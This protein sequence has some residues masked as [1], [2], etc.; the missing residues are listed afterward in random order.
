MRGSTGLAILGMILAL[1]CGVEV[2]LHGPLT[3]ID[4]R[5]AL[6]YWPPRQTDTT[7]FGNLMYHVGKPWIACLVVGSLGALVTLVTRRIGPALAVT[8]ALG[9]VGLSTL[10]LKWVFPHP[11]VLG[12]LGSFPSGHTGVA[13]VASGL[14]V[15]LLLPSRRWSS[16]AAL[17]AATLW[18]GVMGWTRLVL[19]AHWLSDV[20]AGWGIGMAALVLALRTVDSPLGRR[21]WA[22]RAPADR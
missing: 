20:I 22:R 12:T 3:G 10:F 1:V 21:G 17:V 6:S 2:L 9:I 4:L 19:E 18:G 11:S 5:V 7:H 15:R 14:V 16:R 8:V 13:V